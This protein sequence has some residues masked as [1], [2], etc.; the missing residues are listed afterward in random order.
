M[1][2]GLL[3]QFSTLFGKADHAF[4]LDCRTLEYQLVTLGNPAPAIVVCDSQ[5]VAGVW[6]TG[7]TTVEGRNANG[8]LATFKERK[9]EGS[10]TPAPRR[11]PR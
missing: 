9:P 8:W 6:P 1:A 2:S 10:V 3:D 11:G 5:D 4:V 7:C